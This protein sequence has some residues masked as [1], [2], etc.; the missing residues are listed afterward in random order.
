MVTVPPSIPV[1]ILGGY[2]G[3]GKTT[4]LNGALAQKGASFLSR[5]IAVLV[6]DFGPINLDAAFI[7]SYSD[8]VIEL[9]NGC[10]C[11][12]LADGFAS[13]LDQ[14]RTRA[15]AHP[16]SAPEHLI[17]ETS[18]VALPRSVAQYAYLPGFHLDSIVVVADA[19]QV[20][21]QASDRYIG[22]TI[23]S[24]LR[25]AD[26][27]LLTK[28]DLVTTS[29]KE[30]AETFVGSAAQATVLPVRSGQIPLEILLGS[31]PRHPPSPNKADSTALR[32]RSAAPNLRGSPAFA[33]MT[34]RVPTGVKQALLERWLAK[35][36]ISVIR[37]KGIVEGLEG[38]WRVDRV[39]PRTTIQRLDPGLDPN[40]IGSLISLVQTGDRHTTSAAG[41]DVEQWLKQSEELLGATTPIIRHDEALDPHPT[42]PT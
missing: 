9:S 26:L 21:C 23:L 32:E 19:E 7:R 28:T 41:P 22:E 3:A 6:N 18:G 20:E 34:S 1:T 38:L 14:V 33:V 39:G 12:S 11:C 31:G 2:L 40:L 16:A 10:I 25:S 17:I 36:P 8:S 24:Q 5:R 37:V 42:K 29:Q 30:Q 15:A 4:I 27:I 13:A 35:A